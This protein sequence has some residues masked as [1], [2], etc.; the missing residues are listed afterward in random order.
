MKTFR[1]AFRRIFLFLERD[2][3]L[4]FSYRM[5]MVLQAAGWLLTLFLWYYIAALLDKGASGFV[6]TGGYF[7]YV[8]LGLALQGMLSTI[9][10]SASN[11]IREQQ[12][13]GTLEYTL[14]LLR[15]P[16][17]MPVLSMGSDFLAGILRLYLLLLSAEWLFDFPLGDLGAVHFLFPIMICGVAFGA[18]GNLA[19]ASVLLFKRGEPITYFVGT[20]SALFGTVFFPREVLPSALQRVSDLIPT[21][22]ALAVL[23]G[24]ILEGKGVADLRGHYLYLL[25]FSAVLVPLSL[26]LFNAAVRRAKRDGSLGQY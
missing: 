5:N 18:I 19:A 11:R 9:L 17:E 12:M 4:A 22:H 25:A 1:N 3:R 14:N 23:R 16:C 10:Y 13:N 20:A 26:W 8:T 2:L 6:S 21:T 15:W 24:S 7:P